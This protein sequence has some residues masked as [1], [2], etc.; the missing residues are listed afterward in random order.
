MEKNC[1]NQED[2]AILIK[3]YKLKSEI[4]IVFSEGYHIFLKKPLENS[5]NLLIKAQDCFNVYYGLDPIIIPDNS[6]KMAIKKKNSDNYEEFLEE[7]R[8]I[9]NDFKKNLVFFWKICLL[10]LETHFS[11]N[12]ETKLLGQKLKVRNEAFLE[13]KTEGKEDFKN[14]VEGFFELLEKLED[15]L[16]NL[17][18]NINSLLE[19]NI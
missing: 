3:L 1:E 13:E 8:E 11:A 14:N 17:N 10:S 19:K 5:E 6:R 15:Y 18:K 2:V 9:F 7:N 4:K 12:M 16:L